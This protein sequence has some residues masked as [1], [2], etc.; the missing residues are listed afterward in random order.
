MTGLILMEIYVFVLACFAGYQL[1]T[2]VPPTL[3]TPLMSG[4]NAIPGITVVAALALA[5]HGESLGDPV[6][7]GLAFLAV[8]GATLNVVGGFGVTERMLRMFRAKDRP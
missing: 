4:A 6:A 5:Q 1:I 7:I 3:H 2:K 8:A